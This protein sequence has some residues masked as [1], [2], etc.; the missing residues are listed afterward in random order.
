LLVR[1]GLA[2][3]AGAL[4]LTSAPPPAAA[5]SCPGRISYLWLPTPAVPGS[6]AAPPLVMA[7][8]TADIRI[9]DGAGQEI[10]VQALLE[11][12]R[13]GLCDMP[14]FLIAPATDRWHAGEYRLVRAADAHAFQLSGQALVPVPAALSVDLQVETH[15]PRT[16]SG[17]ACADPKID[18]RPFSR[19]A[20]LAFTFSAPAAATPLF[21]TVAVPDPATP[22]GLA[23]STFIRPLDAFRPDRMELPLEDGA[24]SCAV[25]TVWDSTAAVVLADSLCADQAPQ[26][27]NVPVQALVPGTTTIVREGCGCRSAGRVQDAGGGALMLAAVLGLMLAACRRRPNT[28]TRTG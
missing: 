19:T 21:V 1:A 18:G 2:A 10:P 8:S 17:P 9:Q 15:D 11:M 26:S 7:P 5:C 24:E 25:V 12:P 3:A 23:H 16:P 27:R 14:L 20:H 6:A 4:A 22:G 28:N 13:L